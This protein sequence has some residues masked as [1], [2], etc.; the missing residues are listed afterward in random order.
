[1][2]RQ[3]LIASYEHMECGKNSNGIPVLFINKWIS[4]ND[5]INRKDFMQIY[6]NPSL[7]PTN[8]FFLQWKF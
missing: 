5:K 7:C 2:T 4:Y 8:A 1:M 6:P 3:K